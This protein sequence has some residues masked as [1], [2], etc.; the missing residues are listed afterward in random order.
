MKGTELRGRHSHHHEAGRG[1][2]EMKALAASSGQLQ[3]SRSPRPGGTRLPQV[4]FLLLPS[5]ACQVTWCWP[6]HHMHWIPTHLCPCPLSQT[7]TDK[8]EMA[9]GES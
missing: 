8:E 3:L 4:A 2:W 6:M 1:R 5:P 9:S 7:V